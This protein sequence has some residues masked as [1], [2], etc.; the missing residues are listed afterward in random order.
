[1]GDGV[2][3]PKELLLLTAGI[4]I[5]KMTAHPPAD[6]LGLSDIDHLSFLI[7]EIIYPGSLGKSRQL[8]CGEVGREILFPAVGFEHAPD[9]FQTA[10][11]QDLFK[12]QHGSVG[13]SARTMPVWYGDT[14]VTADI[15]QAI[16]GG[17]GEGLPAET[18]R[19]K[20][21]GVQVKTTGLQLMVEKGIIEIDIVRHEDG[22]GQ[23]FIYRGGYFIEIRGISHHF[24]VDAGEG[25]YITGD[26][27]P[28]INQGLV[29]LNLPVSIM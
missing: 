6:V 21:F 25:L 26:E 11:L 17:A 9:M 1:M 5:G 23:P 14:Q 10:G 24:I 28:G 19:T 18:D 2:D 4:I 27:H 22:P 16:A 3:I 13:V 20:L 15:S 12:E 8:S 7:M 29:P